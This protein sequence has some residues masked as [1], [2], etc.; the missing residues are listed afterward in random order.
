GHGKLKGSAEG[1]TR[2]ASLE[3]CRL[4]RVAGCNPAMQTRDRVG[5]S[6]WGAV[7]DLRSNAAR[8]TASGTTAIQGLPSSD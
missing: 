5:S 6:L 4:V 1:V 3:G 8:C 2:R 7:P